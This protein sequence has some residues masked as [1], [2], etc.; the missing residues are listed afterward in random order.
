MAICK[1]DERGSRLAACGRWAFAVQSGKPDFAWVLAP[2]NVTH[3]TGVA[4]ATSYAICSRSKSELGMTTDTPERLPPGPKTQIR[5]TSAESFDRLRASLRNLLSPGNVGNFDH[6]ELTEIVGTPRG[7]PTLNVL[8]VAVFQEGRPDIGDGE[9]TQFLTGRIRIDGFKDWV[10]GAT[11]TLRPVAAV[12]QALKVFSETRQWT[13][14]GRPLAT[15]DFQVESAAF[16]P[17]DGSNNVPFNNILKNNFWA[18]SHVFRLV[19]REKAPFAPFFV[20][21][22]RLQTLSNAI[23]SAVPMAFAGLADLLGDVVIQVP[24][25]ILVPSITAP[26][27]TEDSEVA[28]TWRRGSTPRPLTIAARTRWD[29]LLTGAAVSGP[30]CTDVRLPIN[31]HSQAIETEIWDAETRILVGATAST[32]IIKTVKLDIHIIQHEPRLFTMLDLNG[33]SLPIRVTLRDTSTSSIGEATGQDAS[34]WLI[35]RQNL[36]ETRRLEE[37]RDFVQYRPK[38]GSFDEQKRALA[39]VHHL[40]DMHGTD[41]VDLWDPYLTGDDLLRTLFWC[42]HS[43]APLRALTDGRDPP[44]NSSS[45]APNSGGTTLPFAARQKSVL[46]RDGGNKQGL[47]LEYRTRR[48]P[49]GW[50]FHDRFLI[51]PRGRNG[52]LAWSLGTSVNSLGLAHHILQRVSNPALVAGAFEE[53]WSALDEAQHVVWTSW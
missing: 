2:N 8:S 37:T 53:L 47:R 10:F 34:Y 25:T 35:R 48:G 52:P 31:N 32:S 45:S 7:G 4:K 28:V 36:E 23:A 12:D 13:L 17:P 44:G 3:P 43:N 29:E 38:S 6:I 33:Q 22:L 21:R 19:D 27:H 50:V 30:F 1:F 15:C 14:S 49:K 46:E 11:R 40:I 39:D 9:Q 42:G 16:A 24:V 41:G 26:R 20:D 51:F 18:G 5:A